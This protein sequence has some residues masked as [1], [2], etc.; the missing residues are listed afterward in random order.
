LERF[1]GTRQ[2][3]TGAT[4]CWFS[5]EI[6]T[7]DLSDGPVQVSLGQIQFEIP[8]LTFNGSIE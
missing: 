2:K 5:K 8:Q 6:L 7:M 3:A 4:R 1:T